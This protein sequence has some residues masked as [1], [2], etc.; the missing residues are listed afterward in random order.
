M[1]T[2]VARAELRTLSVH[3]AKLAWHTETHGKTTREI[4]KH[5]GTF[6]VAEPPHLSTNQLSC[7]FHQK[8]CASP[9]F[10]VDHKHPD[11]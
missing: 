5:S 7:L 4:T 2:V 10:S 8:Q 11:I 1:T 9:V 6:E 3:E